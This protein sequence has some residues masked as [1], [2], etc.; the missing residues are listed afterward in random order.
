M[1]FIIVWEKES[2]LC[3][4]AKCEGGGG[5]MQAKKGISCQ[6]DGHN[7]ERYASCTSVVVGHEYR[8]RL[9][10]YMNMLD[11]NLFLA[12]TFFSSALTSAN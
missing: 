12:E 5:G 3:L 4:S 6:Y 10:P 2:L 8:E 1:S 9:S 11:L 7:G